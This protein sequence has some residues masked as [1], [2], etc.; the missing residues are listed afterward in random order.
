MS[1]DQL[2]MAFLEDEAKKR[3]AADGNE[4]PPAAKKTSRTE[5][6]KRTN[7]LQDSLEGLPTTERTITDP[8]VLANPDHFRLLGEEITIRLHATPSSFTRE[9]IKR[10][11]HVRKGDPDATPFTPPLEPCLL[12]GSVLTP[13][14]GALLLTEKF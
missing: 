12:P 3:E 1:A 7:K 6:A 10:Q 11:T 2:L 9:I 14:L 4:E 8:E 13:S 5:R